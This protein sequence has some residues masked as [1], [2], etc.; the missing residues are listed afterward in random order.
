MFVSWTIPR[1]QGC[2]RRSAFTGASGG[3]VH[4]GCS[5]GCGAGRRRAASET[6]RTG[7][8]MSSTDT[9]SER[10]GRASWPLGRFVREAAFFLN[11]F[12][13]A[14][15]RPDP[16]SRLVSWAGAGP[17]TT[18]RKGVVLV[19]G[20][21]GLLG[22]RVVRQLLQRGYA[23]R[24]LVRSEERAREAFAEVQVEEA[25]AASGDAAADSPR[26]RL[27]HG[28]LQQT[29]P[30]EAVR[31]VTAVI[32]CTGARVGP[33]DDTPQR[34]KYAQ[35]VEFH[36][37]QV[38]EGTPQQVEYAGVER[39]VQALRAQLPSP[40]DATLASSGTATVAVMEMNESGSIREHWG[41]V[42]DIVMGG[43]SSSHL[44]W[45]PT[46]RSARFTGQVRTENFGG[47]A[48]VRTLPFRRPLD[49]R[50]YDGFE[51]RVRGDGQRYKFI[52]RCDERWDGLAY[53]F[54]FDT[55]DAREWPAD[56]WQ[57]V[58]MPFRQ[59][60]PVF[61][62]ST[63]PN[64][65]PLDASSIRTFQLMLSKFE[66]DGALNPAFTPGRFCLDV[67]AIGAYRS[68][69]TAAPS[70]QYIH[71]S[72]AGVTRVLRTDEFPDAERQPPA[73]RL[74]A[75]LGRLLEWKLAGEDVV[76]A[77]GI[78]YVIVRPCALTVEGARGAQTLHIEQGD[79][80][81]GQ[82]SRDDLAELLV[83][84][85]DEPMLTNKTFEVA[86]ATDKTESVAQRG[87]LRAVAEQLQ[88]DA[89]T[90][91]RRQYAAFPYVPAAAAGGASSAA[92]E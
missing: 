68:A 87:S 66:Y 26:L 79:R 14:D 6:P 54:S 20:A 21:S 55:Q 33:P 56:Q 75:L 70:P 15:S 45:M 5:S 86:Y 72:S 59:F 35:G 44:E 42:D 74:N 46:L 38:L 12:R 8:C 7:L 83:Q 49:L 63:R 17:T 16:S 57:T 47:F 13:R 92:E 50:P 80:L 10:K 23:V 76:R 85:L 36:P 19:A 53:C 30:S 28:D 37:P 62:A 43:V 89:E 29:I 1:G 90:E 2:S 48:S 27:V 25:M 39:L 65:P 58:R 60:V 78:P 4:G 64:E 18:A 69:P 73:V 24:A 31:G 22:R 82:V 77:S 34:D 88:S 41:A 3:L 9:S 67:Q 32:G 52:V 71:V 61:R 40:P 81:T 91:K 51:L 84:C 11:P